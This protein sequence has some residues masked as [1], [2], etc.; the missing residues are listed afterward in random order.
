M[1]KLLYWMFVWGNIVRL[2]IKTMKEER[3]ELLDLRNKVAS[4]LVHKNK[5]NNKKNI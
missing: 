1:D 2:A 5:N 4:K 3:Y